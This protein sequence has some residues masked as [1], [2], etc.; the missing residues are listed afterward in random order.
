M[1]AA[2]ETGT[3]GTGGCTCFRVRKAA[4]RVTQL[5]DHYLAGAGLRITQFSLLSHLRY[6]GPLTMTELA[7]R[8]AMDRTTLT[9][10]LRPLQRQG[11]VA[12]AVGDDRRRR[13][14]TVTAAGERVYKSGVGQWQKAQRAVFDE[15]GPDTV[16]ELHSLLER[17]AK[18]GSELLPA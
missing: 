17:T 6:A 15:L 16:S 18:L 9:R 12:I 1:T 7:D 14:L 11:F 2:N 8:M 5:Y 3:S 13:L 10:N 4:R